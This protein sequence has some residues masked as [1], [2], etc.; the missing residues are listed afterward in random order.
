MITKMDC[1]N[2]FNTD[3]APLIKSGVTDL[4]RQGDVIH[5]VVRYFAVKGPPALGSKYF[6]WR[7]NLQGQA[8]GNPTEVGSTTAI[9]PVSISDSGPEISVPETRSVGLWDVNGDNLPDRI[10]TQGSDLVLELYDPVS[11][12]FVEHKA[13]RK[14]I[15]EFALVRSISDRKNNLKD[16]LDILV[17][18]KNGYVEC[19]EMGKDTF[20]RDGSIPP[21]DSPYYRTYQKDNYEPNDAM[22]YTNQEWGQDTTRFRI[23][24]LPSNLTGFG[25]AWSYL[26]SKS[27]T[28]FFQVKATSSSEICVR[29]PVGY[30]YEFTV[31]SPEAPNDSL[32]EST[33]IEAGAVE[34][35]TTCVKPSTDPSLKPF[36]STVEGTNYKIGLFVIRIFS[37]KEVN[38]DRPYWIDTPGILGWDGMNFGG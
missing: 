9:I 16:G 2:C 20:N 3:K 10:T 19:L 37:S 7:F 5:A 15:G 30:Q 12:T 33:S 25:R 22:S 32:W 14:E 26:E 18:Y 11:E 13:A 23:P 4:F 38:P 21:Y 6:H 28:D 8:L 17:A 34:P 24:W 31:S 27:D 29:S 36:L 1:Q 35:Y